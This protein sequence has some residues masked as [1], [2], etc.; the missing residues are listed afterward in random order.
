MDRDPGWVVLD[1]RGQR[2]CLTVYKRR[3]EGVRRLADDDR[4]KL[5]EREEGMP[6]SGIPS[7]M[8]S[9]WDDLG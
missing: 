7:S 1:P 8:Q 9:R 2:V 3:A 4:R 6:R 5:Q